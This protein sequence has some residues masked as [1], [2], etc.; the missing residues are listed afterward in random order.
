MRTRGL[1][2]IAG[3]PLM[4][5]PMLPTDH[6]NPRQ[7]HRQPKRSSMRFGRLK[8]RLLYGLFE[9]D[10]SGAA[11]IGATLAL[12]VLVGVGRWWALW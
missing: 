6:D 4:V 2:K 8:V 5:C 3:T 9:A 1:Q 10:A 7:Q 12:A 11:A